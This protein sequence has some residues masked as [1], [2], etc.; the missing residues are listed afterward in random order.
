M[1]GP[2]GIPEECQGAFQLEDGSIEVEPD[3]E[4]RWRL[5]WLPYAD[6]PDAP[7]AVTLSRRDVQPEGEPP[8]YGDCVALLEWGRA[9]FGSAAR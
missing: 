8:P 7:P 4:G 9:H 3:G 5:L 2:A 1:D 6:R